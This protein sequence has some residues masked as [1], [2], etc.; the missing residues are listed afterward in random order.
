M[1][2]YRKATMTKSQRFIGRTLVFGRLLDMLFNIL[3]VLKPTSKFASFKFKVR[4]KRNIFVR[5]SL[6]N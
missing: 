6:L 2:P 5:K 3:R 4:F 1:N